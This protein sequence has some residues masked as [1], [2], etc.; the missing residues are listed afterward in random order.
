M[1]GVPQGSVLG[2]ILFVMFINDLPEVCCD[3]GRV[4]LFADD[5]KLFRIIR[6][7]EDSEIK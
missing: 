3:L 4:F 7:L 6:C 1:S 2:P 5:A